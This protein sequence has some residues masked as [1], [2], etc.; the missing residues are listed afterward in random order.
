M[1][2]EF[3][4]LEI[5]ISSVF[6]SYPLPILLTVI[7]I[8]HGRNRIHSKTIY[9]VF[10]QP[11]S[12]IGNKEVLNLILAVI[13]DLGSPVGMFSLSCIRIFINTAS[14]EL[15]KTVRISR[16]MSRHPVEYYTYTVFMKLIYHIH[17]I[18]GSTV[19]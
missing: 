12:G 17:E 2:E 16:K 13:K 1:L 14:V 6:I 18:I 8:Q 11:K 19:S 7:K 3:D 4:S 9:M 15:S 5:L 10:T